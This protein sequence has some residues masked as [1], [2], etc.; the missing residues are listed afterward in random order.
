[1]PPNLYNI[2]NG[3]VKICR[4]LRKDSE[5]ERIGSTFTI[6][7]HCMHKINAH[8]SWK[9]TIVNQDGDPF[10]TK[11]SGICKELT[12]FVIIYCILF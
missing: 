4:L 11:E 12:I 5:L 9:N 3:I 7:V 8:I 10:G 6:N 2:Q 1:M